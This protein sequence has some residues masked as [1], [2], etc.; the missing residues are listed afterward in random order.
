M[1]FAYTDITIQIIIPVQEIFHK[2]ISFCS[3][4]SLQHNNLL[5]TSAEIVIDNEDLQNDLSQHVSYLSFVH[6]FQGF[7]HY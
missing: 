4:D 1:I 6:I 3:L 7:P 5:N 2:Q